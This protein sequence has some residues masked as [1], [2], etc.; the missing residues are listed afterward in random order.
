MSKDSD[1]NYHRHSVEFS[2]CTEF[3][4]LIDNK[5]SVSSIE[6]KLNNITDIKPAES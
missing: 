1:N 3:I 2:N 5:Y 4:L 6:K